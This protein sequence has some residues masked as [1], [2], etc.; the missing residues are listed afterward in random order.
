MPCGCSVSS[1]MWFSFEWAK[2]LSFPSKKMQMKQQL[3]YLCPFV[4]C[5]VQIMLLTC[6]SRDDALCYE[7]KH[8]VP[9]PVFA[10]LLMPG[11]DQG[12]AG[13]M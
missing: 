1:P 10:I 8:E 13:H 12:G 7:V 11:L 2:L 4:T 6:K 9:N 5:W 3:G